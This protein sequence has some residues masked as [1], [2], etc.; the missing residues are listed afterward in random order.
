MEIKP[1]SPV[2]RPTTGKRY[3]EFRRNKRGVKIR[4][5]A[6]PIEKKR[7]FYGGSGEM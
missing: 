5:E 2:Y 4:V 6:K 3:E 1:V 7:D